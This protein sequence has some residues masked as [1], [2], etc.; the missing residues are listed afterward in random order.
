MKR[1]RRTVTISE[2]AEALGV[3]PKTLYRAVNRGEV[4][5]IRV[6]RRLLVPR[7]FVD[8]ILAAKPD[9]PGGER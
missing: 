5:G 2:A 1:K 8:R 6:G 7:D 3:A 9:V 4:P